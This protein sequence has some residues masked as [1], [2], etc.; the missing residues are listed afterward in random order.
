MIGTA[1]ANPGKEPQE[2]GRPGRR[3][4]DRPAA[5]DLRGPAV[6]GRRRADF[7]RRRRH[8]DHG[9]QV[10]VL[11]G[12][13][14]RRPEADPRGPPAQDDRQRLPG[15]RLHLRLL[16]GGRDARRG[17]L[18]PAGRRRRSTG[19]YYLA[20]V[21]GRAAG[22]LAYGAAIAGEAS[23]VIGLEDIP[24]GMEVD[25]SR[26]W[27]RDTGKPATR[28]ARASRCMRK[29]FDV[30]GPGEPDRRYAPGP[31]PRKEEL[32][33]D[34]DGRGAGRVPAATPRSASAFPSRRV[35]K[36]KPDDVR[37]FPRLPVEVQRPHR[38]DGGRGVQAADRQG[39][40]D[41]SACSSATR[42]A[43]TGRP[44]ST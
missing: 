14:A 27:T 10:Q 37:P 5:D 9:G 33:R 28:R 7:D 16:H 32:R 29:I 19:T 13:P 31:R 3:R 25:R 43:A 12:P 44:P 20:Q 42:S 1:R 8:A 30:Q 26:P 18:Q 39:A 2:A 36:L 11:P 40:E 24:D 15:D 23:L 34:R 22:W 41:S 21:M 6:A 35:P 4:E 38:A 17:D